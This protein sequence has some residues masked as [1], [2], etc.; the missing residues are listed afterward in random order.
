MFTHLSTRLKDIQTDVQKCAE[1]ISSALQIEAEIV[2]DELTVIAGTG[3]YLDKIGDKEEYGDINAGFLYGRTI[4]SMTPS[5]ITDTSKDSMYDPDT[6]LGPIP[7]LAEICCPITLS[8]KAL[9]AIGLVAFNQQQQQFLIER[10]QELVEF[11]GR[12]AELLASKA[13]ETQS[14]QKLIIVSNQLRTIIES[15]DQGVLAIDQKGFI[16]HCNGVAAAMIRKNKNELI[17][18]PISTILEGSSLLEVLKTGRGHEGQEETFHSQNHEMHF[19]ITAKPILANDQIEGVVAT[20]RDISEVR[21]QAYNIMATERE[22]GIDSILGESPQIRQLR[23]RSRQIA[24]SNATVLIT[25]ESGTGKGLVATAIHYSGPRRNGP[26]IAI[27]CAAIPDELLESELFGYTE[28]AF[29]GARK[30]GKPGKFELADGGT[31][32]LDEIGDL[33]LR[34]QPKLLQVLQSRTVERLGGVKQVKVNVRVIASTNRDL[35]QMI[36]E[37]EF[38]EDLFYRLN[39]IPLLTTPFRERKGDILLLMEHFLKKCCHEE[40]KPV[41][42]LSPEVKELLLSYQWPG[43]VR[44]LENTVEYMVSLENSDIITRNSVPPRIRKA[45]DSGDISDKPLATLLEEYEKE[46]F[47]KKLDQLGGLPGQIDELGKTLQI[48]RATLYRKLKKYGFLKS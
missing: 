7:E 14:K 20:F 44:E 24:Q 47:K 38:R 26:F 42:L 5:I 4:T 21:K 2:D 22:V 23:E 13:A 31:I 16:R 9:G 45:I 36:I 32:C 40:K 6:V 46:L 39:V 43:N 17:G 35:E 12:M 28:G 10:Q 19:L 8:G 11:I 27:N 25:G 29:S 41:K 1:A 48:S 37:R 18:R 3:L 30:G 33:P 34:L 15:I